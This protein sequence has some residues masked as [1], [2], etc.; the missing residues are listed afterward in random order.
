MPYSLLGQV[1]VH[2]RQNPRMSQVSNFR[3]SVSGLEPPGPRTQIRDVRDLCPRP[4]V[5]EAS[6]TI[7]SKTSEFE[8]LVSES[9]KFRDREFESV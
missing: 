3:D 5:S 4:Y 6:K 7:E 9:L 2:L 8:A 1:K